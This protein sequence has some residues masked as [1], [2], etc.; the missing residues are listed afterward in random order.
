[1]LGH[2]KRRPLPPL[3]SVTTTA[4]HRTG[5]IIGDRYRLTRPLG[6]RQ[7]AEMWEAEHQ[8][9]GRKVTIKLVPQ[10]AHEP[11]LRRRLAAEARA[12]AEAEHPS[13]VEVYDFGVTPDGAAYLV[14][15]HLRGETLA[16]IVSRQG[17][18]Q[19]EDAC[20]VALQVLAALDAIHTAK[21]MHGNA[22]LE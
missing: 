7:G 4:M 13:I 6:S 16:D 12:A 10:A 15:E 17:A 20:Q 9:V 8:L 3:F 14:T 11:E 2:L 22:R 1:H 19:A 5:D 18:M 21:M